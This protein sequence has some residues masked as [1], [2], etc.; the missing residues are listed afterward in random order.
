MANLGMN[1]DVNSVGAEANFDPVPAGWYNVK[2]VDSENKPT[3]AGDGWYVA[4][5]YE[6]LDGQ[7]VGRRLFENLNLGNASIQAREIA[8]KSLGAIGRAVGVHQIQDTSQLH[9][10]PLK[11]KVSVR[12]DPNGQYGDSNNVQKHEN[13]NADVGAAGAPTAAY[14][15]AGAPQFGAP[16]GG[17]P[18]GF[19][20]QGQP[21]FGA[22]PAGFPTGI[23]T[24]PQGQPAGFPQQ[25]PQQFA[26]P[27]GQPQFAPQG[28]PAAG[29]GPMPAWGGAPQ[30]PW[31]QGAP[32]G[33][34]QGMPAG[35]P[36]PAATAPQ[37]GPQGM[38]QPQPAGAPHPA[39]SANP[40]W[41]APV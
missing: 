40:P 18:P 19:A 16:Q 26:P 38:P 12:K 36:A 22:P 29:P 37:P 9:G 11:V 15:T 33:Q 4:V 6:I 23:Q 5:S 1:F 10:I 21:Q 25:A 17:P 24:A 31:A 14:P 2:I 30:Q 3:K 20:P 39:Q 7:Y 27:Q 41:G 32:Q 28:Q 35:Q 8:F 34:P 13:V